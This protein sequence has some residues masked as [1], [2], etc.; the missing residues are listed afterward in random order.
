MHR[1]FQQRFRMRLRIAD[2]G[3]A[4]DE[5][6]R[7]AVER[8]HTLQPPQH[9]GHVAAEHAAVGMHFVDHHVAQVLEELRP[10]G[11]VRQDGLVQHVRI[12]DHDVAMQTDRLPR[13]ARR[14]TVEGEG[15][16][17]QVAGLAQVEQFRHL[18]LRQ[19]LGREQVQRLAALRQRRG[20]HRQRVADRLA[21][22]GRGDDGEVVASLRLPPRLGLV[23]IQPFDA[24]LAQRGG[25]CRRQIVG[26]RLVASF[27]RGNDE[28]S[29]DP[30]AVLPRQP[31]RQGAAIG[32][33]RRQQRGI[34]G[35]VADQRCL[36]GHGRVRKRRA[37]HQT[38]PTS[39]LLRLTAG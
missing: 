36:G 34:G 30:V 19:R 8:A 20:H 31:L 38:R 5:L 16:Q 6:R 11:V 7:G 28:L 21:G 39:H 27:A 23:R 29:G 13:I 12:A 17:A 3:R 32:A 2:G 9:V 14:V 26:Q 1:Q 4:D 35:V 37:G 24:A 33:L 18:V 15:L 25:Q 10:L 22:G